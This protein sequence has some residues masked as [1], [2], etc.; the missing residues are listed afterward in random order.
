MII[1]KLKNIMYLEEKVFAASFY[2]KAAQIGL[3]YNG[4]DLSELD[5]KFL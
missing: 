4:T 1:V 3:N 2:L 5:T